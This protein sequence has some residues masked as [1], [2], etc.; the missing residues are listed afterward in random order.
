MKRREALFTK[1]EIQIIMRSLLEGSYLFLLLGV[2]Y[3]HSFN[4]MH[5]D[6]KPENILFLI[7]DDLNSL[8]IADFGLAQP[9][10]DHP[11][12]YPKYKN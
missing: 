5:R 9:V 1:P 6:L 4:I 2:K 8:K 10:E 3:I 7:K 12:L 11:F